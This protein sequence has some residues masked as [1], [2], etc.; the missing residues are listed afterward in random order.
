MSFYAPGSQITA[1]G[2]TFGGTSQAAPF[3]AGS[4][5][6]L[7]NAAPNA[8]LDDIGRALQ[9]TGKRVWGPGGAWWRPRIDL[10]AAGEALR[11]T[12]LPRDAAPPAVL[13][14]TV[15]PANAS[16]GGVTASLSVD[17][18]VA[19]NDSSAV[20]AVCLSNA[21]VATPQ[22]CA[23]WRAYKG[24][25][26]PLR[27]ALADGADGLRAVYAWASD[28]AGNL[29]PAPGAGAI[30]L[31][32][33][34][35][36]TVA[37]GAPGTNSR[38]VVVNVSVPLPTPRTEMC[39]TE[40][41]PPVTDACR[42][43]DWQPYSPSKVITLASTKQ[44]ER[45]ISV[46]VRNQAP[47]AGL[48]V[49]SSN[50]TITLDTAGPAMPAAAIDL[51]ANATGVRALGVSFVRAATDAR[52]G[53]SLYVLVLR[54]T[55]APAPGCGAAAVAA[56]AAAAAAAKAARAAAAAGGA[57]PSGVVAAPPPAPSP[58]PPPVPPAG[59]PD[60]V[61]ASVVFP[62]GP[63][64]TAAIARYVFPGLE[65]GVRYGVRVCALDGVG[66]AAAGVSKLV[67]M[68]SA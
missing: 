38:S 39:I 12:P 55:A 4:I 45:V 7:H 44:G 46:Y 24:A 62:P 13:A 9:G 53:V 33:A 19:A 8:S 56:A 41:P 28:A 36:V 6:V 29:S 25:S 42:P 49:A 40:R 22:A 17:V 61:L 47:E 37:D 58:S 14:V 66:N 54:R 26:A 10:Y 51:H 65:P 15:T 34:P 67:T 35:I 50:A 18:R 52:T 21:R 2:V 27:W 68:P 30:L 31:R 5:A 63:N 57:A 32:R 16:G 60:A 64:G 20:T 48:A 23:P 3:V 59:A 11:G 1:G 43:S